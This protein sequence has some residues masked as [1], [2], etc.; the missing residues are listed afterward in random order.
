MLP[1]AELPVSGRPAV[2]LQELPM[3]G[4][5]LVML[6]LAEQPEF[7]P[8]KQ[9]PCWSRLQALEPDLRP[10]RNRPAGMAAAGKAAAV[11][12][13]RLPARR[14]QAAEFV[15]AWQPACCA[16]D[17]AERW[18]AAGRMEPQPLRRAGSPLADL[19]LAGQWTADWRQVERQA[20]ERLA[21]E[22]RVAVPPV[23]PE[24][25]VSQPSDWR[26]ALLMP[27]PDREY[28]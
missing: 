10:V 25:V 28:R 19:R 12:A 2:V 20:A 14:Q 13:R 5:R 7:L 8:A 11:L 27:P 16:V 21:A 24:P 6:L 4:R 9:R 15:P 22:W 23:Q 26:R 3:A 18:P 1:P 17:R